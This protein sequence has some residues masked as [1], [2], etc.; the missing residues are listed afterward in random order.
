MAQLREAIMMGHGNN[1][2]VTHLETSGVMVREYVIT[3]TPRLRV[4][5][6]SSAVFL[7]SGWR[8]TLVLLTSKSG[9]LITG[10]DATQRAANERLLGCEHDHGYVLVLLPSCWPSKNRTRAGQVTK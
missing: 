6:E 4:N 9:T 7:L 10:V 5:Q 1:F 2:K 8:C 3:E